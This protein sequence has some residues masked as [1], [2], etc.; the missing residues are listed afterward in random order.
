[1]PY[2]VK[3][4]FVVA[5]DDDRQ[6]LA[7]ELSNLLPPLNPTGVEVTINQI[8]EVDV[9][10]GVEVLT[11]RFVVI[12]QSTFDRRQDAQRVKGDMIAL[13]S[14]VLNDPRV[15]SVTWTENNF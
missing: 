1:M 2:Q 12:G 10:N 8:P 13:G 15:L 9:A 11:G 14:P 4:N 6:W 3:G 5:N 7:N